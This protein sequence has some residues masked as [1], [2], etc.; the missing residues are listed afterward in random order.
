MKEELQYL[1]ILP[2]GARYTS[3]VSDIRKIERNSAL[4]FE[5]INA[6]L[7]MNESEG[8][9]EFLS[10]FLNLDVTERLLETIQK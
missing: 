8:T 4:F 5:P 10:H 3:S 6:G 2:I 9:G 7:K 1:G